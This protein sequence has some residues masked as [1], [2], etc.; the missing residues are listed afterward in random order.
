MGKCALRSYCVLIGSI[1]C[2]HHD[3]FTFLQRQRYVMPCCIRQHYICSTFVRCLTRP[4]YVCIKFSLRLWHVQQ[5]SINISPNYHI[6]T[7]VSTFIMNTQNKNAL[8]QCAISGQ[9]TLLEAAFVLLRRI[10]RRRNRRQPISCWLRPWLSGAST[11]QT[12]PT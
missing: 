6:F 11:I 5:L 7:C 1:L 4:L 2:N 8:L 12:G 3:H 9:S 10:R